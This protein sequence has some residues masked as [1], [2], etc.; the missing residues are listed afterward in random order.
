MGA[1]EGDAQ[2]PAAVAPEGDAGPEAERL[3]AFFY[4]RRGEA[5]PGFPGRPD[6]ERIVFPALSENRYTEKAIPFGLKETLPNPAPHRFRRCRG[7]GSVRIAL[8]ALLLC[9][10]AAA[11]A[12][13]RIQVSGPA[14]TSAFDLPNGRFTL[15]WIHSVERTEWRETFAVDSGGRI[16]L[17]VSEFESAGAGLPGMPN[18]GE[19]VRLEDGKMRL[20]GSGLS[21]Q[22]LRVRLS[23]LSHHSL[24][25]EDRVIDLNAMFGEGIVTIRAISSKRRRH[26]ENS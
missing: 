10:P 8:L 20:T 3:R 1:P 6:P 17:V 11:T 19:V 18:A 7:E 21:V 13:E 23:D 4:R 16:S 15:S 5:V 24:H 26:D 2:E 22:V 9:L 14:G 25:T 12:G